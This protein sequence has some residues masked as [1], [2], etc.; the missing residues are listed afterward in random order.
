M[1][2]TGRMRPV[3]D[4]LRVVGGN[5][6]LLVLPLPAA[7]GLAGPTAGAIALELAVPSGTWVRAAVGVG[8][9]LVL[10]VLGAY[11]SA[12]LIH[13][14]DDALSGRPVRLGSAYR[15]AARQWR[16][17]LRWGLLGLLV[18]VALQMFR[19]ALGSLLGEL[20]ATLLGELLGALWAVGSYLVLPAMVLDGVGIREATRR[21]TRALAES[22]GTVLRARW[23]FAVPVLLAL[24][25]ALALTV[26]AVEA[27]DWPL[28]IAVLC[29]ALVLV[30]G[31]AM[32]GATVSGVLRVRLYRAT[33]VAA[34]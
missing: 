25:P 13:A 28:T 5:K 31:T 12:V 24:L 34:A 26:L 21:S 14:A 4:A 3:R 33:A 11:F 32:L 27:G 16:V 9:V 30:A 19:R 1:G 17:L 10:S 7:V 6:R 2:M 15:R 29:A 20:A 23:I 18:N 22:G 8:N